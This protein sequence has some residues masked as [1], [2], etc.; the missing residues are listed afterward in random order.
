MSAFLAPLALL[1]VHAAAVPL[2]L[3]GRQAILMGNWFRH[4][5]FMLA[6]AGL[7][8]LAGLL[9]LWQLYRMFGNGFAG[10]GLVDVALRAAL[11]PHLAAM[12]VLAVML[13]WTLYRVARHLLLP[14]KLMARR[15]IQ[16]WYAVAGTGLVCALLWLAQAAMLYWL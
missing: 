1:L 8:A 9:T 6:S 4:R 13:T 14:H 10:T 15:T 2:L 12:A 7:F 16:V 11:M 3:R 5:N